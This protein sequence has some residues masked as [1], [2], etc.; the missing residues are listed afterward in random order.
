MYKY[1]FSVVLF[2]T[3]IYGYSQNNSIKSMYRFVNKSDFNTAEKY[4]FDQLAQLT[5]YQKSMNKGVYLTRTTWVY[6]LLGDINFSKGDLSKAVKYF[7][8]VD[9][10][11]EGHKSLP[12]FG[13]DLVQIQLNAND[14]LAELKLST[15]EFEASKKI[16]DKNLV[17]RKNKINKYSS[18][19]HRTYYTI[20]KYHFSKKDLDSSAYFYRKY[21]LLI[22]NN[23]FDGSDYDKL[24]DSYTQLARIYLVK[25]QAEKALELA[26]KGERIHHHRWSKGWK[27]ENNFG[28]L[29]SAK[30]ISES[31]RNLFDLEN[32]LVWNTKAINIYDKKI[33]KTGYVDPGLYASRGLIYWAMD[34]LSAAAAEFDKSSIAF[35][36]LLNQNLPFLSEY[37][38][39]YYYNANKFSIDYVKAF[40]IYN[41]KKVSNASDIKKLYEL[42]INTKGALLNSSMKFVDK[43]YSSKDSSIIR[44]Y[45]KMK[46]FKNQ[47][48]FFINKNGKTNSIIAILID[49]IKIIEKRLLSKLDI[50]EEKIITQK[51]I[52][53]SVPKDFQMVDVLKYSI[54]ELKYVKENKGKDSVTQITLSGNYGYAYFITSDD[55][56]KFEICFADDKEMDGKYYTAYRNAVK[57]NEMLP[58]L[59]EIYFGVFEKY[60]KKKNIIFCSDGIYN[61]INISTLYD[62]TYLYD[63]YK[64]RYI[65]TPKEILK[66]SGKEYKIK[67]IAFF[68]RPDFSG[69]SDYYKRSKSSNPVDLPGTEKEINYI[70]QYLPSDVKYHTYL[71]AD[72]HEINVK[73]LESVSV[74]HF[75]THGFFEVN[76]NDNPMLNSGLLLTIPKNQSEDGLL[77]AYE[78]SGLNLSETYLVVLSACETGLGETTD[79]EG[80]WGL[81]RSF[82]IAGVNYIIMSLFKVDDE[83]TSKLMKVF[84]INLFNKIPVFEAFDLAQQEIKK[85]YKEPKYWGAF[86]IKGY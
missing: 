63:K 46:I 79:G 77:T 15:G 9:S 43:I 66:V 25:G 57:F 20:A 37:E 14:I 61:L 52:L 36:T 12:G 55:N 13:E 84:Y 44:D 11:V 41:L 54:P 64:I 58:K 33:Q 59:Y 19:G 51:E 21:I 49:S 16:L 29:H 10:I 18:Y 76:S 85:E 4:C 32:A 5:T 80:V 22:K 68:G 38:R 30:T 71:S 28:L 45:K 78:A 82:Q 3:A 70:T 1:V 86:V 17:S 56:K 7:H 24:A 50:K 53:E 35:F 39:E 8:S 40:Y 62:S 72:A 73:K 65:T 83:V 69:Y 81:Q 67:D 48:S 34:N 26:L 47:L 75:A 23:Y 31:Y 27:G 6:Y 74:I 60:I 2:F 42:N